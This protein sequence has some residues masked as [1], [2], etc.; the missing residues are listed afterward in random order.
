[1]KKTLLLLLA[2][3]S[4]LALHGQQQQCGDAESIYRAHC[5]SPVCSGIYWVVNL[6][7]SGNELYQNVTVQC[8]YQYYTLWQDTGNGCVQTLL[9]KLDPDNRT[10]LLAMAHSENILV[11]NCNGALVPLRLIAKTF[12]E[13]QHDQASF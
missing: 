5:Y 2:L 8:C 1:M 10:K 13:R 6:D 12:W 9:E 4:S 11:R 3:L 7:P